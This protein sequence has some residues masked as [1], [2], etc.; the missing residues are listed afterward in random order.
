[1]TYIVYIID[2]II[3]TRLVGDMMTYTVDLPYDDTIV[4]DIMTY[5]VYVMVTQFVI[6]T[7]W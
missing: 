3:V 2:Y 6:K 5:I 7:T 4:G 1:M